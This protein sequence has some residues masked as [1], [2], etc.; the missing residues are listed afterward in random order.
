MR[1][2]NPQ[3][4]R[5]LTED[6]YA[7]MRA[8]QREGRSP[9]AEDWL[10]E[11]DPELQDSDLVLDLV[12][13]ELVLREQE[14]ERP[15]L[16]EFVDRFPHLR[17]Q[18]VR[19]FKLHWALSDCGS[20][21]DETRD[22]EPSTNDAET[23]TYH[24]SAGSQEQTGAIPT[25]GKYK[26]I[27]ELGSG[28]QATVYR[29]VHSTL[30]QDVVIK[31]SRHPIEIQGRGIRHRLAEEGRILA[32]LKS[33]NIARIYDFDV[34]GGHP[35]VVM[36]YVQGRSLQQVAH[37]GRPTPTLA[38]A[39]V[40]QLARGIAEAHAKGVV[41]LDLK[42]ANVLMA[43]DGVPRLIDFGLG[44]LRQAW[45]EPTERSNETSGTL[46]Y[47]APERAVGDGA[48]PLE[49][50]DV[51]GLG[52]I[53]YFLLMGK[54]PIQGAS[55]SEIWGKAKLG[56]WNREALAAA[57]AELRRVCEKCLAK[58]PR[59]RYAAADE[60][61]ADLERFAKRPEVVRRLLIGAAVL[62]VGVAG[63]FAVDVLRPK[64][65][66]T[67]LDASLHVRVWNK[68]SGRFQDLARLLP[69]SNTDLLRIEGRRPSG[70]HT[71]LLWID[72]QGKVHTPA[73]WPPLDTAKAFEYP[74]DQQSVPLGEPS[75][76]EIIL[77]C[78]RRDRP[79]DV[80]R[81]KPHFSP[82]KDAVALPPSSILKLTRDKVVPVETS[83]GPGALVAVD[84]P[85]GRVIKRL[86][87]LLLA[88]RDECEFIEGIAVS[89]R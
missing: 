15:R 88:L 51:F 26:V 67:P 22:S 72:A 86:E 87:N 77:L 52:G 10:K 55:T 18:L 81:L 5:R 68:E 59:A 43:A 7:E 76:T 3:G 82:F 35:F 84:D 14:G 61:A 85:E 8:K 21:P 74:A 75:G 45:H 70:F 44:R 58:D 78:G 46:P 56:E 17:E 9:R 80:E 24:G 42:P 25:I 83:R 13:G 65:N 79:I 29:A 60:L 49:S 19:Q 89:H 33:K 34:D 54:P 53:L 73:E 2:P 36:E 4:K 57:P 11:L 37:Q 31:V 32:A 23:S 48:Y 12:Y 66:S 50:A 27:E 39:W 64:H 40:A 47:M 20:D 6:L 41:H 69:L 38:A 28:G 63:W 30:G 62:V 16:Q 1:S 71:T